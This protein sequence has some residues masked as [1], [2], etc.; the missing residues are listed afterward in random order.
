[1]VVTTFAERIEEAYE[2]LGHQ[3]GWR[4]LYTPARTLASTTRLALVGLNPGGSR[5]SP[6]T[7]SVERGSAYRIERWGPQAS[8]N[9]LQ[10]Q[11]RR[12]YEAI[13]AQSAS[14][15]SAVDLMDGTLAANLCPFRSPAW[16]RLTSRNESIAFSQALWTDV[17]NVASPRVLICLGDAAR[18][19]TGVMDRKGWDL[20]DTPREGSVGWGRY[21][22]RISPYASP[23]GVMLVVRLPHLSRFKIFGRP[24]SRQAVAE[25]TAAIADSLT[26]QTA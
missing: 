17:L 3:L 8:L 13:A 22:Y 2:R 20:V 4:F 18:Y 19:L 7:P 12:M 26:G 1:V 11:I 15:A 21:T 16:N 5:Y 6:P 23:S 10:I 14:A 25:I 9:P 24:Q